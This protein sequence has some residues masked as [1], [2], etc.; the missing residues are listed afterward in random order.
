MSKSRWSNARGTP[1]ARISTPTICTNVSEPVRDVVV[2]VGRREPREVHPRP[3]DREEHE[4]VAHDRVAGVAVGDGVVEA[5]AA[6]ATATTKQRSKNS[7]SGVAARSAS[8]VLRATIGSRHGRPVT[9]PAIGC[10]FRR[11]TRSSWEV[12]RAGTER[13]RRPRPARHRRSAPRAAGAAPRR[14]RRHPRRRG[15]R[16]RDGRTPRRDRRGDRPRARTRLRA[17][18]RRAVRGRRRRDRRRHARARPSRVPRHALAA[19]AGLAVVRGAGAPGRRR[20]VRRGAAA[21]PPRVPATGHG[22]LP[23]QQRRDRR[24]RAGRRGASGCSSST[25]TCTTATAPRTSSGTTRACCS[26]RRTSRRCTRAP[27]ALDETGGR[28]GAG[29]DDQLPAPA[30]RDRRRRAARRSTR[31]WRRAVERSRPRGCSCRPASTPT[32]TTRSPTSRGGRRLRR[33]RA[34]GCCDRAAAA[35]GRRVPRGRLRPRR[36]AANS[37]AA[38]VGRLCDTVAPVESPTHG[39]P[40]AEIVDAARGRRER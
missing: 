38:T 13:S 14:A 37:V 40:G 28:R 20:R 35:T 29:L 27:A 39:G 31:S 19:G 12:R 33:A 11:P 9:S 30:G 23:V 3:P 15:R 10:E 26:C 16:V 4:H 17:R 8:A 22:L 25:G 1:A 7:S 5:S 2:V 36:A 24:R 32:A 34:R 6:C 21:G 18:P